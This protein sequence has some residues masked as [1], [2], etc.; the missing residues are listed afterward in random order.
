MRRL[1]EPPFVEFGSTFVATKLMINWHVASVLWNQKHIFDRDKR[2]RDWTE[3]CGLYELSFD[4]REFNTYNVWFYYPSASSR[5]G[6]K[7]NG[8]WHF[9]LLD[10]VD[11]IWLQLV[12]LLRWT[13]SGTRRTVE[14]TFEFILRSFRTIRPSIDNDLGVLKTKNFDER[15]EVW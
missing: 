2:A 7:P 8:N 6:R 10:F 15:F 5:E 12:I 14:P 9:E 11:W 4:I 13:E 3:L 1:D